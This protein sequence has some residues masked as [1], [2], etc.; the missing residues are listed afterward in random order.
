VPS[1][2]KRLRV[3]FKLF[4]GVLGVFRRHFVNWVK[5]FWSLNEGEHV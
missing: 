3:G 1:H 5:W 2:V 4:Q